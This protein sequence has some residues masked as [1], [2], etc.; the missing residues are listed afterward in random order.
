M[1]PDSTGQD[2]CAEVLVQAPVGTLVEEIDGV[3]LVHADTSVTGE[4]LIL[5]HSHYPERISVASILESMSARSSGSVR[6]R[7]SDLRTAKMVHGD[8]KIG[9]RLT[10]TGHAAAVAEIRRLQATARSTAARGVSYE[11]T[12]GVTRYLVIYPAHFALANS[13]F[14][15]V[16]GKWSGASAASRIAAQTT[17]MSAASVVSAPTETR[18]IHRPSR[19]AGVR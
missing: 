3:R 17:S 6:N 18:A 8:G 16:K 14:L 4:I 5:L 19:I 2:H 13:Q 12:L 11:P 9:Y 1:T 10:Q 15:P 7:L